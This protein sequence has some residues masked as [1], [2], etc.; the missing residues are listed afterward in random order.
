MNVLFMFTHLIN[1]AAEQF[2]CELHYITDEN[3]S[4]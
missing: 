2:F 3:L 1:R 4:Y